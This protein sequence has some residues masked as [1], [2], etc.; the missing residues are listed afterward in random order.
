MNFNWAHYKILAEHL[1]N[2]QK[3]SSP[4]NNNPLDSEA[5][6]RTCINRAYYSV[7]CSVREY[8]KEKSGK[9]FSISEHK[10]IPMYLQQH[11]DK[12]MK[13]IGSQLIDFARDRVSAD[14]NADWDRP[15]SVAMTAGK[16][17]SR[18]NKILK[19]LGMLNKNP[20]KN[21]RPLKK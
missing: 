15:N 8:V 19:T 13:K 20:A 2:T 10:Q 3:N 16:S 21:V 1:F 17:L 7:F 11:S 9:S 18:A 6:Y 4:E 5:C 12:T 14:Y